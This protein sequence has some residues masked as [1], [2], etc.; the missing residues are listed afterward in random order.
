M[1]R[2]LL[3]VAFC[4]ELVQAYLQVNYPLSSQLPP[5]A[6]VD[7]PFSFQSDS[8]KLQYS[9]VSSPSWLSIDSKILT[10]SG[11]PRA[12]DV[13]E[14]TFT[15]AASGSAGAVAK[16]D[17][18]LLVSKDARLQAQGNI[19][20]VLSQAGQLSGLHTLITGPSKHFS[21]SFSTDIFGVNSS[22][23]SCV[24]LLSDRTPLPAW[25]SF[26]ASS[27]HLQVQRRRQA[28]QYV[29][30]RA[31]STSRH[32]S[33]DHLQMTIVLP[34]HLRHHTHGKRLT[35]VRSIVNIIQH[36]RQQPSTTVRTLGPD[37]SPGQGWRSPLNGSQEQ[38]F[39]RWFACS[40]FADSA[41][42]REAA[43]MART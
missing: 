29:L 32:F 40:R 6:H 3:V 14:I 39:P 42:H 16:M 36:R 5:I 4:T 35:W 37:Y 34:G 7:A 2:L 30:L 27:L 10:L 21:V 22:S 11:T 38:A 8:D 28:Q 26:D 19:T 41:V 15:I 1:A 17:S 23:L 12:S 18:R 9:L 43:I 31:H 25:I 20:D 24:A 13:G 33:R